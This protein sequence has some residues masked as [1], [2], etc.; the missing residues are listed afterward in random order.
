MFFPDLLR[1]FVA[2]L[3]LEKPLAKKAYSNYPE[4]EDFCQVPRNQ[5]KA[6]RGFDEGRNKSRKRKQTKK[7]IFR[8]KRL[9]LTSVKVSHGS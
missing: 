2:S 9:D 3:T 5:I 1:E 7:K 8:N 4:K 6:F